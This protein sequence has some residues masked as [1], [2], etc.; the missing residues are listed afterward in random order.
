MQEID[1]IILLLLGDLKRHENCLECFICHYNLEKPYILYYCY[2]FHKLRDF[3]VE[4]FSLSDFF[5]I[6]VNFIQFYWRFEGFVAQ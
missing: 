1:M 3:F 2:V 5:G 4:H 6:P